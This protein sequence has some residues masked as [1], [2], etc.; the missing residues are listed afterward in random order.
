M[1]KKVLV[2]VVVLT[3]VLIVGNVVF[4]AKQNTSQ[5][6]LQV[7]ASFYPLA[8]FAR[9]IGK[10]KVEVNNLVPAGTEPHDFNPTPQ[11]RVT[12]QDSKLFIYNGAGFEPWV[13][14]ILPDLKDV[15]V[16]NASEGIS[17]LPALPEEAGKHQGEEEAKNALH[18]P[19]FLLDPV[20]AQNVVDNI[21]QKLSKV[22]PES[23]SFYETNAAEYNIKLADLDKKF[24]TELSNCQKRDFITSH[25]AFAYLA[26]RY[27]LTQ[28]PI[29]GLAQ[30]EPSPQR[31]A[32]VTK[33]AKEKNIKYIFFETLVSPRLSETIARE[34][35]AET[36]VL[37]PVAGLTPEEERAGKNYI[38]L[39]EKNLANLKIALECK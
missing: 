39:M 8:E 35:G 10:D 5:S 16:R 31:L 9:Q 6:K 34:V 26:K 13:D 37:N 11:D 14:K 23:S 3:I 36:L 21:S 4:T 29:A 15:V 25:A 22:D 38:T 12:I 27:N 30:E 17:L 1:N 19:H 24:R 2:G 33:L 18:D 20:F 7:A 28:I 32:E